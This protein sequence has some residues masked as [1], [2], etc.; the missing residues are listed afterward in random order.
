MAIIT[1][2]SAVVARAV[3][4]SCELV[5]LF[6]IANFRLER[7]EDLEQK[8]RKRKIYIH[9]RKSKRKDERKK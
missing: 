1:S 9:K 5:L 2:V 8:E 3:F 6:D 7:D 4:E